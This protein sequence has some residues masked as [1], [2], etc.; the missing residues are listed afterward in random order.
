MHVFYTANVYIIAGFIN[1]CLSA[2][3]S[4]SFGVLCVLS[5]LGYVKCW[6]ESI[7]S[8]HASLVLLGTIMA[9]MKAHLSP[10][11]LHLIIYKWIAV[12]LE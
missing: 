4:M 2:V 11:E 3:S 5:T 1:T 10:S 7:A 8:S 9:V 12:A 6:T